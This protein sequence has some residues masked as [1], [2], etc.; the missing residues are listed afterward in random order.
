M[1]HFH[2]ETYWISNNFEASILN[3][4][5]TAKLKKTINYV[6]ISAKLF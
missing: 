1:K 5:P 6:S 3:D 2:N 4:F